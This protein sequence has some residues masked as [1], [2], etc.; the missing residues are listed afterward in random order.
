MSGKLEIL[1]VKVVLRV[2]AVGIGGGKGRRKSILGR[3]NVL[4]KQTRSWG[5]VALYK[6]V[7]LEIMAREGTLDFSLQRCPFLQASTQ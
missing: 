6:E 1:K 4:F 2:V 7:W 5:N 3:E